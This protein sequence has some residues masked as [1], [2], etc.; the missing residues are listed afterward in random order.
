M[1]R[2]I[3]IALIVCLMVSAVITATVGAAPATA[4]RGAWAANTA[5]AVNDTVTYGGCSYKV[6][7][8]HTSLTG[9]E[10]PTTPALFQQLSC[11][12]GATNTPTKTKT[13]TP[14]GP[15]ATFTRTNT[16]PAITFTPSKTNTRTNTPLVRRL[17]SH[18]PTHRSSP[19][20]R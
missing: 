6:L 1:R 18:A 15:T 17:P 20:S 16:A 14:V 7:Q 19:P 11:G 12:G 3:Y 9:W 8:A 5:Y 2:L 4:D 13:N 10:P